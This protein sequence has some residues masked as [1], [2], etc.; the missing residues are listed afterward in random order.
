MG[1]FDRK[2]WQLRRKLKDLQS[3]LKHAEQEGR[4]LRAEGLY[5][6]ELE[7]MG[8]QTMMLMGTVDSL[9]AQ[10]ISVL[11]T[12]L[13]RNG[14]QV[15][16]IKLNRD[17]T[18]IQEAEFLPPGEM[19]QHVS[20]LLEDRGWT[21]MDDGDSHKSFDRE[22]R[23]LPLSS[24]IPAVDLVFARKVR[25][26]V[27]KTKIKKNKEGNILLQ[28]LPSMIESLE[29]HILPDVIETVS[30]LF[31]HAHEYLYEGGP[32]LRKP[33]EK[34]K[35]EST[36]AGSAPKSAPPT[37]KESTDPGRK[38]PSAPPERP[39]P[40]GPSPDR[41]RHEIGH[42]LRE[43]LRNG[44]DQAYPQLALRLST[45]LDERLSRL[46]SAA[47]VSTAGQGGRASREDIARLTAAELFAR[48][49]AAM[50][51]SLIRANPQRCV[52]NA[53]ALLKHVNRLFESTATCL[54]KR[55]PSDAMTVFAQAGKLLVWGDSGAEGFP[56]STT[57]VRECVQQRAA[58][59]SSPEPGGAD[60][61]QSMIQHGI[62]ACAAAP[63][64]VNGELVAVLYL[65]RRETLNPFSAEEVKMAGRIAKVFQEFA[66]LTLGIV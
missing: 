42:E 37:K 59:A 46:Q 51:H 10:E 20:R 7:D 66:D 13:D 52:T 49:G 8:E 27:A 56:I 4:F 19:V 12:F 22:A 53:E 15:E 6:A 33:R 62:E 16:A 14:Y 61:S 29:G 57:I 2:T 38:P 35:G 47:E 5:F 28:W 23:I 44:F 65:D 18:A 1:F 32:D 25:Q 58:V 43:E 60:P 54:L 36:D 34:R 48:T 63:V 17:K 11:Q 55:S 41:I 26:L 39:S 31:A 24:L 21:V 50:Y 30:P 9:A 3:E 40:S 45:M 64:I